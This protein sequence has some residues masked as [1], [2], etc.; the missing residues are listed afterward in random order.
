MAIHMVMVMFADDYKQAYGLMEYCPISLISVL[1]SSL[2]EHELV[3]IFHSVCVATAY[4]HALEQPCA[5]RDIKPENVI[6]R[7]E[8]WK[9]CDFGS[10]STKMYTLD[11]KAEIAEAEDDI[12]HH[13]TLAYRAPEMVDLYSGKSI[14]TKVDIWALGCLFFKMGY[15][16]TPFEESKIRIL[17]GKV[18]FPAYFF[19]LSFFCCC[20]CF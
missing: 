17:D 7:G 5:H 3:C 6:K 16:T 18:N 12:L 9:L 1:G 4:L 14:T 10:A 19:F 8:T 15:L 13:T 2:S 11:S 20:C